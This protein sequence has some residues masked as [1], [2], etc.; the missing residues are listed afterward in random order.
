MNS[1]V[2]AGD[3]TTLSMRRGYQESRRLEDGILA[4]FGSR[5]VLQLIVDWVHPLIVLHGVL[6]PPR[7]KLPGPCL[8]CQT[9]K[10]RQDAVH[11]LTNVCQ[12][13]LL[14]QGDLSMAAECQHDV[15]LVNAMQRRDIYPA[16]AWPALIHLPAACQLQ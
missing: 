8:C 2:Q 13:P 14:L 3:G 11:C 5:S 10:Q 9:L 4:I 16:G 12:M 15:P 7:I 6:H 1:L